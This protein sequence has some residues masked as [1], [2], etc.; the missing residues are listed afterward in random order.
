MTEGDP[1]QGKIPK[2]LRNEENTATILKDQFGEGA[3]FTDQYRGPMFAPW[4]RPPKP[5][6]DDTLDS[7]IYRYL[8]RSFGT[9]SKDAFR[10]CRRALVGYTRR[11]LLGERLESIVWDGVKRVDTMLQ[12]M[13]KVKGSH[14]VTKV[15]RGY[16]LGAVARLLDPGFKWD[17]VLVLEGKQRTGKTYGLDLLHYGY[18]ANVKME[19]S[20]DNLSRQCSSVWLACCDELDHMG[21]VGREAFKTWVSERVEQWV[22]KYIEYAKDTPRAFV[23]AGT[24]NESTY[25]NDP[26]G[27]DRFWP[28]LVRDKVDH[29]AIIKWRDQIWAEAIHM[30]KELKAAGIPWWEEF[31]ND[32]TGAQSHQRD[33][34]QDDVLAGVIEAAM[35]VHKLPRMHGGREFVTMHWLNEIA[36][37]A[38]LPPLKKTQPM[39][40]DACK[41]LNLFRVRVRGGK[42][43]TASLAVPCKDGSNITVGNDQFPHGHIPDRLRVYVVRMDGEHFEEDEE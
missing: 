9:W 36:Q 42:V 3:L 31:E 24:T 19:G 28:V 2:I 29:E 5:Y 30:Y 14:Y 18:I 15:S 12:V 26:T 40:L 6:T 10:S 43:D 7:E 1:L 17:H 21:K 11:N 20:K 39:V 23:I 38:N 4:G 25:L 33:R 37:G 27:A 34:E 41:R 35:R 16:L 8:E 22:P 32:K 13:F